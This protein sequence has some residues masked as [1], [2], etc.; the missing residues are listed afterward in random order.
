ML[1]ISSSAPVVRRSRSIWARAV[2]GDPVIR[3]VGT[4]AALKASGWAAAA[5]GER[6]GPNRPDR[7]PYAMS[8]PGPA[9]KSASS[10]V[11]AT[12]TLA[13]TMT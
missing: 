6:S 11:S 13:V 2:A 3:L 10:S 9:W 12:R 7:I 5:S 4:L 1:T 8:R